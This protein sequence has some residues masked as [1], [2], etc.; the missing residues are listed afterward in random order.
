MKIADIP[1]FFRP[2]HY[3]V[4]VP[5]DGLEQQL[6]NW[7]DRPHSPLDLDPDFQRGHVWTEDKQ[8]AFVEYCLRGGEASREL[9]FNHPNWMASF[10]GTMVLVDGKQRLEAVRK[11]IRNE[12]PVF[13]GTFLNDFDKPDVL[14]R[15]CDLIFR[16]NN[17]KTRR[18][19]L[20]WYLQLNTGGVV[21]TDE[22]IAK[23]QALLDAEN[24][25]ELD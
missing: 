20:T 8:I 18:E 15:K 22:E 17:L 12:L 3:T 11:F 6:Q 1:Y 19:V 21:H 13:D 4:N 25:K 14:L 10:E 23:V 7:N 24:E 16:V 9:L 2:P 5:W